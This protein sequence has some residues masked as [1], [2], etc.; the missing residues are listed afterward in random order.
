[1]LSI[2]PRKR[3]QLIESRALSQ[4]GFSLAHLLHHVGHLAVHLQ[5][6][7]DVGHLHPEPAAMRFLRLAFSTSGLARSCRGHRLDDRDLAL[8]RLVVETRLR[9]SASSS[10]RCRASCPSCRTCRPAFA[11]A[12]LLGEVFQVEMP[13]CRRL[14]ILAACSCIDGFGGL[15]DERDDVAHAEDAAGDALRVKVFQRVGLFAGTD[16]LDRLAGDRRMA[17]A[18]PPRPSPSIRVSTIPVMPTR[19]SKFCAQC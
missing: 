1:M 13:F 16:Q 14:A 12:E 7:V 11:S 3:L 18:A 19:S 4:L 6:L 15:F 2:E 8:D 10:C 5:K 9:R 17:S